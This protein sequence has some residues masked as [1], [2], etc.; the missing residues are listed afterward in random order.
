M[1]Y[2][3]RSPLGPIFYD[4]NG[5]FCRYIRLHGHEDSQPEHDDPVSHWFQCWFDGRATALPPMIKPATSFQAKMRPALLAI[6]AGETRTYGEIARQLGT[7]ARAMGQALG[8]NPLPIIIPCHRVVAAGGLGGF[9]CGLRWKRKLLDFENSL[10]AEG[11][12]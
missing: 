3:L 5:A 10:T 11:A 2:C 9:A 1:N 12:A 7:S 6:P 4:W 8:A